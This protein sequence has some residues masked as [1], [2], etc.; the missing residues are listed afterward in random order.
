MQFSTKKRFR[1]GHPLVKWKRAYLSQKD[2]AQRRGIPFLISFRAWRAIWLKSGHWEDRGVG[3][4]KYV[5]GRPKD[6]GAYEIG[7]VLIIRFEDNIIEANL[8]R[9]IIFTEEHKANISRAKIG[10]KAKVPK[11]LETRERLRQSH[12]GKKLSE[13]TR[14]KISLAARKRFSQC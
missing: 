9:K 14:L 13:Q 10:K 3:S 1:K 12:L 6:Q 7:N 4:G 2:T 11:S 8:G 5:M